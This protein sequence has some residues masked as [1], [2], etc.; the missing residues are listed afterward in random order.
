[1][2][3]GIWKRLAEEKRGGTEEELE[4]DCNEIGI[5]NECA[6]P[7]DCVLKEKASNEHSD[8]RARSD[9]GRRPVEDEANLGREQRP[10]ERRPLRPE[11]ST[12]L[13]EP[14]RAILGL[15]DR[16]MQAQPARKDGPP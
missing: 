10:P 14:R 5:A 11:G 16:A 8:Y 2:A 1:M 15:T 4:R 13:G 9:A 3:C 6:S 12:H 7:D